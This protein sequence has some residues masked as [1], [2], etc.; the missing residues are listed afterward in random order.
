MTRDVMK[1]LAEADLFVQS[2]RWEGFGNALCE[3][4][5]VGLPVISTNCSG[6]Q[7]IIRNGVDG[8]LV[9]VE[10]I[11]A[12]ANAISDLLHDFSKRQ[13]LANNALEITK[14][15]ALPA[16]MRQWETLVEE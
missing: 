10:N 16:I 4:M 7:E 8:Q 2:S 6:P 9:P 11:D 13:A 1:V 12:L 3:A 5:A 15:F 14:R